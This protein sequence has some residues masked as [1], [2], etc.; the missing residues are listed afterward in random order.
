MIGEVALG[1]SARGSDKVRTVF[2]LLSRS[3]ESSPVVVSVDALLPLGVLPRRHRRSFKTLIAASVA[4]TV[5]LAAPPLCVLASSFNGPVST[6]L[7]SVL[8]TTSPN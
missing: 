7:M 8:M 5:A 4:I 1:V 2:L 6:L 3:S